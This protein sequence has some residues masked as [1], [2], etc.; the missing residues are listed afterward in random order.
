LL[1][2]KEEVSGLLLCSLV[3]LAFGAAA[4][5]AAAHSPVFLWC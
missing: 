5:A 4:A 3:T 1:Q 2:R